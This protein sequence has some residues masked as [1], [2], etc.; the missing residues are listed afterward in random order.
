M[1]P[2]KI[3]EY[4]AHGKPIVSSD[5][6]VI[7][8]GLR[9]SVHSVLVAPDNRSDWVKALQRLR[10]NKVFRDQTRCFGIRLGC[11]RRRTFWPSIA[12]SHAQPTY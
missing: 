7:R 10:E 8:E 9:D 6:P 2:L 4:M 5:L 1:L 12:A 11:R 3:F